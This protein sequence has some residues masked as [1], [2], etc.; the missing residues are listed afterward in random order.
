ME[1]IGGKSQSA[2]RNGSSDLKS[3]GFERFAG[4]LCVLE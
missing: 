1:A 3:T 4:S 2:S